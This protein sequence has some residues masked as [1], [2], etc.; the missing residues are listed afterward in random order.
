MRQNGKGKNSE[1][2][3]NEIKKIGVKQMRNQ[4]KIRNKKKK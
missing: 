4:I 3:E 2:K 1:Q